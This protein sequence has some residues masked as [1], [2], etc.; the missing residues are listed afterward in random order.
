MGAAAKQSLPVRPNNITNVFAEQ[1]FA[2]SRMSLPPNANYTI[3]IDARK[4]HA[5]VSRGQSPVFPPGTQ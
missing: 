2:A 1:R 3:C 4:D 5:S